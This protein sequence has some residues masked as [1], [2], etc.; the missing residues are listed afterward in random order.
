MN[1]QFVR[2]CSLL[3]H[4]SD[5]IVIIKLLKMIITDPSWFLWFNGISTFVGYLMPKP[6]FCHRTEYFKYLVQWQKLLGSA[7]SGSTAL[8]YRNCVITLVGGW[9]GQ[10]IAHAFT[11]C[12]MKKEINKIN[13]NSED[14]EVHTFPKGISLK[15]NVIARLEFELTYYNSTV[16][17]F[18]HYA[19][20]TPSYR[21]WK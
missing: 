18:N 10:S 20:R 12:M 16:L 8:S 6:S 4:M 7:R 1:I 9:W 2:N 17:R 11:R 3:T 15:V 21:L 14:K 5:S 13:H 19:M